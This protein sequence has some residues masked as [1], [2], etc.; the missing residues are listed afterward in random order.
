MANLS[1]KRLALSNGQ[2]IDLSGDDI[3]L[4]V[5]RNSSG[6]S[7]FL[8]EIL[9]CARNYEEPKKIILSATF[10]G[11]SKQELCDRAF[12]YFKVVADGHLQFVLNPAGTREFYLPDFGGGPD[13]LQ[14]GGAAQGFVTLL[15]AEGRLSLTHDVNTLDILASKPRHP[16]HVFMTDPQR[17]KATSDIIAQA[18]GLSI[19]INRIGNPIRG[20]VGR[21]LANDDNLSSDKSL[22]QKAELLVHQ[23]DGLRSFVGIIGEVD[24]MSHPIVLIDEPEAFLHSPQAKRLGRNIVSSLGHDRQAFIA[25]HDSN[26]LQGAIAKLTSRLRVLRLERTADSFHVVDIQ[27]E[28]LKEAES[29]PSVANTNLL[30]ALFYD[31]TLVCE[32]DAD[33]KLFQHLITDD[34][35]DRFWFSAAGKQQFQKVARLLSAFGVEWRAVLDLDVLLDWPILTGLAELKK[36]DISRHKKRLA[37]AL[38]TMLSP[39]IASVRAAAASALAKKVDDGTA[40]RLALAELDARKTSTPLKR[41]GL[42]AIP[43][44][45]ERTHVEELLDEL[46]RVGILLLRKGQLESYVPTVGLH[47]PAWVNSVLLDVAKYAPELG[48]LTAELRKIT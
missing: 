9:S 41:Y 35:Q 13:K 25:T 29:L 17:L 36:L 34:Q 27:H 6:K 37:A 24:A 28:D 47:G 19:A 45:Q 46:A 21:N 22:P 26:F 30:D 2:R 31:E 5:G 12:T 14:L 38:K 18:F 43:N 3:V 40:I 23:G 42:A 11:A 8:R 33:C 15:N 39:D 1:V 48:E 20:Y 32:G 44:G 4:V 7:T 10:N 16:F